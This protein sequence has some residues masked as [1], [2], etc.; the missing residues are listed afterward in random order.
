MSLFWAKSSVTQATQKF[1]YPFKTAWP[2][3][4]I[5][6]LVGT[7]DIQIIRHIQTHQ[8]IWPLFT[9]LLLLLIWRWAIKP[10]MPIKAPNTLSRLKKWWSWIQWGGL[11]MV[12]IWAVFGLTIGMVALGCHSVLVYMG[13]ALIIWVLVTV[14]VITGIIAEHTGQLPTGRSIW[15]TWHQHPIQLLVL[16]V[17]LI[18]GDGLVGLLLVTFPSNLEILGITSV[19]ILWS[20]WQTLWIIAVAEQSGTQDSTHEKTSLQSG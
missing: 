7:V 3:I 15:R 1:R 13:A 11:L 8:T 16:V 2:R 14:W 4:I 5:L 6:I 19:I 9:S 17:S 18:A 20:L 10:W 12:S